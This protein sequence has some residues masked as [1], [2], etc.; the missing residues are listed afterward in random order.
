MG[1]VTDQHEG[2]RRA[3]RGEPGDHI[4][5]LRSE[6]TRPATSSINWRGPA[7]VLAVVLVALVALPR[8]FPAAGVPPAASPQP[9][10]S[11]RATVALVTLMPFVA[12]RNGGPAVGRPIPRSADGTEYFDGIPARF[13]GQA[14]LRVRDALLEPLGV[15]VLVGG[16]YV[17]PVCYGGPAGHGD[18]ASAVLS[19]VP[20]NQQGAGWLTTDWLAV[21]SQS[22]E[23]GARIMRGRLEPD[24]ACSISLAIACQPRL[25]VTSIVWVGPTT[26]G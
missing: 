8:L 19:D 23:L 25:Q 3:A 22:A 11:A 10:P 6:P 26:A 18:C 2:T 4:D 20:V 17:P 12:P 1:S 16:W 7:V 9:T 13:D 5:V 15:T 14:V 21:S 24:P